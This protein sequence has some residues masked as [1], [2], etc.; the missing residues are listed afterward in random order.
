LYDLGFYWT[1]TF[2]GNRIVKRFLARR[3][4]NIGKM[5]VVVRAG[6]SPFDGAEGVAG[7]QN[8]DGKE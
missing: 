2:F 6:L 8:Q 5:L 1:N 4:Y 3:D 7:A